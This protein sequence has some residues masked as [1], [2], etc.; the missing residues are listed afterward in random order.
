M[1][2]AFMNI[3]KTFFAILLFFAFV[4]AGQESPLLIRPVTDQALEVCRQDVTKLM[5]RH[6]YALYVF[7]AAAAVQ[8]GIQLHSAY[9][10]FYPSGAPSENAQQVHE[11]VS[12]PKTDASPKALCVSFTAAAARGGMHLYS[13]YHHFYPSGVPSGNMQHIYDRLLRSEANIPLKGTV[14]KASWYERI[15]ELP[16]HVWDAGKSAAQ[17][18]FTVNNAK[19]IFGYALLYVL[20]QNMFSLTIQAQQY[21]LHP[22]TVNWYVH[23][24]VPYE[25]YSDGIIQLILQM[26]EVQPEEN[27]IEK[28]RERRAFLIALS[29]KLVQSV[30][31][32]CGFMGYKIA[33]LETKG[34]KNEQQ[35]DALICCQRYTLHLINTWARKSSAALNAHS[36]VAMSVATIEL[37]AQLKKQIQQ[38]ALLDDEQDIVRELMLGI[39][40]G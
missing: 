6:K 36:Y 4:H 21:F 24:D 35:Y 38:F 11:K 7:S 33:L 27:L 15:K 31:R 12:Q 34:V 25:R 30:S 1:I 22:D 3:K 10:H 26:Y 18:V 32:L 16:V 28:Q 9:R 5:K 39:Y 37:K 29:S 8:G 40:K 23:Y 17:Q 13:L 2:R 20:K 14:V 19:T